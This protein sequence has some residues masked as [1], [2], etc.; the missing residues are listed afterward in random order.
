[1][2]VI[3]LEDLLPIFVGKLGDGAIIKTLSTKS[4]LTANLPK[5]NM[6]NIR[7]VLI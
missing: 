2:R 4:S 3:F 1:M 6:I 7:H 5:M